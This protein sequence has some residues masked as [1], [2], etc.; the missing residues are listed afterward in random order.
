MNI[1]RKYVVSQQIGDFC[2]DG[3]H[4]FALDNK[5]F[6]LS[7]IGTSLLIDNNLFNSLTEGNPSDDL[8]FRL[9]QRGFGSIYERV[10]QQDHVIEIKPTF[11]VIDM[12]SSCNL[13]C[14]YCLRHNAEN[15]K[16]ITISREQLTDICHYI[17]RYC[18]R[19]DIKNITVQPWGGEPL[20][21]LDLI[22][23]A[24]MLFDKSGIKARFTIQTNGTLL[25]DEISEILK[26]EDISF[27]ISLDG[28]E[29][30]HDFYR[31]DNHQGKTFHTIIS[32]IQ[33]MRRADQSVPVSI[34]SVNTS[35]SVSQVENSI[36]TLVKDYG[37]KQMKMNIVHPNGNIDD[38]I[39]I[40][41]EQ[42]DSFLSKVL[43]TFVK[44]NE[45][46]YHCVESNIQDRILNLI[47]RIDNDICHSRGCLGGRK[48]VSFSCEGE[49]YPCELIGH[50][51]YLMGNIHEDED[52]IEVIQRSLDSI[53][54]FDEKHEE[55]CINCPW[56]YYC[57]GGCRAVSLSYGKKSNEID[58]IEC[59]V[60]WALYPRII[61]LILTKPMIV[62]SLTGN[63][64]KVSS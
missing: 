51:E 17:I 38:S 9:A 30:I 20:I 33:A 45:E 11:F 59:A 34:I 2:F 64:I 53:D 14:K 36:S 48:F 55:K 4:C 25:N 37:I 29:H 58:H 12:T 52:L 50:K 16:D 61:E 3:A 27:G 18:L 23:Y 63:Y 62:E 49:I 31:I 54:Y 35:A 57:R 10:V 47:C 56:H 1:E 42:I 22:L 7:N 44:L 6:L 41:E 24:K 28:Y 39:L 5:V 60:N 40:R 32:N 46:G 19:N 21:A 43:N 15:L 13:N 8:V 26:K